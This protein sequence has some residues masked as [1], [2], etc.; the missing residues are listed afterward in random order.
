MFLDHAIKVSEPILFTFMAGCY[1]TEAIYTLHQ[2]KETHLIRKKIHPNFANLEKAFEWVAWS[3][4]CW[5]V[6]KM[7]TDKYIVEI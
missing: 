4:L 5:D 2:M 6:D 7:G 1:N 3:V